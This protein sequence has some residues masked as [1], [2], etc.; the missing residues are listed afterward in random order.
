MGWRGQS[1][2][3]ESEVASRERQPV[4]GLAGGRHR[5]CND[6]CTYAQGRPHLVESDDRNYSSLNRLPEPFCN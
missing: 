3:G 1:V 5:E 6:F 2:R 4:G